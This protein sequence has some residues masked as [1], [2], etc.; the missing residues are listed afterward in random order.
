MRPFCLCGFKD[1][2]KGESEKLQDVLPQSITHLEPAKP[3][4]VDPIQLLKQL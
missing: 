1:D 2:K 4:Q 3:A